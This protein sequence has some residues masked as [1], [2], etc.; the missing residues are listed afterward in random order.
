MLTITVCVSEIDPFFIGKR[1]QFCSRILYFI[2]DL[3]RTLLEFYILINFSY[4][5]HQN[6]LTSDHPPPLNLDQN[7]KIYNTTIVF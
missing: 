5:I 1:G 2:P 7:H 4:F 6:N 3:S